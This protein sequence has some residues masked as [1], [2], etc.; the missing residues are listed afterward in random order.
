MSS[1]GLWNSQMLRTQPVYVLRETTGHEE[2]GKERITA[3]FVSAPVAAGPNEAF[4]AQFL[5]YTCNPQYQF[6]MRQFS[7]KTNKMG[8]RASSATAVT[9]LQSPVCVVIVISQKIPQIQ[10]CI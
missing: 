9:L 7:Q 3:V 8:P 4:Y 2:R 6:S 5:Y 1:R 10:N